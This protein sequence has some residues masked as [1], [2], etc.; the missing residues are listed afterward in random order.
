MTKGF[1]TLGGSWV[2]R[3][4]LVTAGVRGRM[5]GPEVEEVVFTPVPVRLQSLIVRVPLPSP[6]LVSLNG[7]VC[8]LCL[9][10]RPRRQS[11][12]CTVPEPVTYGRTTPDPLRCPCIRFISRTP[13][14]RLKTIVTRRLMSYVLTLRIY[15]LRNKDL[16]VFTV[17]HLLFRNLSL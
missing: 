13:P 9:R 1:E 10:L 14:L 6:L 16:F 4:G 15:W 2:G 8:D 3:C 12:T 5:N 17:V 7:V 11:R